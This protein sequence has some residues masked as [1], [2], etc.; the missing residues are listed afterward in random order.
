MKITKKQL[1]KIIKESL[2]LEDTRDLKE[3][4]MDFIETHAD[5]LTKDLKISKKALSIL[6]YTA[7]AV[8]GRESSF[9]E[10][11]RYKYTDWLETLV[12]YASDKSGISLGPLRQY[13]VGAG[14]TR[15]STVKKDTSQEL[16]DRVDVDSPYDLQDDLKSMLVVIA[17]LANY[18]NKAI[19]EGYSTLVSG[20]IRGSVSSQSADDRFKSTG[21]AA[22][23]MAIV[24][25][26]SGPG[27]IK[28]YEKEENY[29]PCFGSNCQGESGVSTYSYIAS[30]SKFLKGEGV[31][32]RDY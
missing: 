18:Y 29:I 24:G 26:N 14:Q 25:Y 6:A 30:I 15:Y 22:L 8:T 13:S 21:N 9:G 1:V 5:F 12:S 32:T 2:L 3:D 31:D 20:S 16:R 23:D 19:D 11:E 10:G 28:D 27:K 17:I 7:I 4:L